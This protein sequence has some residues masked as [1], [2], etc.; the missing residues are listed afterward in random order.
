VRWL[1]VT[2][3]Q[4]LRVGCVGGGFIAGRHL[5]GLSRLP[6]VEVGAVADPAVDRA[7]ATASR[8]GATSY[9]DGLVL[10]ETEELD[11]VW[12]CV[13]P[14]AHG[15]L[16]EAAL[17]RDLPFFVEKPLALDAGTA[18][19]IAEEVASRGLLTAVGY[20]WRYLHVVEEALR[21][22]QEAGPHLVLGSWLDTTPAPAWWSRRAGSGGQLVE[23]TTHLFDLARVL[24]GEVETVQAVEATCAKDDGDAADVPTASTVMLGFG[25]GAVGSISSARVLDARYRVDLR[26]VCDGRV[27]ELRERSL[28]DHELRVWGAG[29]EQ[30]VQSEQDPIAAEDQAFVAAMRG[31]AAQVRVPYE[32]AF[33][34]HALVCAADDSARAAAGDR[35]RTGA[36]AGGG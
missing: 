15:P 25:S 29:Q 33:L 24:A 18:R 17:A 5:A 8:Y 4:P 30:V 6:G 27:V 1:A 7:E 26:L 16:E 10:L 11:A 13:P 22:T 12:L 9:A 23:Q 19:R 20:H 14:F 28:T 36:R 2:A 21:C 3:V 35:A 34:T 32:E 31:E